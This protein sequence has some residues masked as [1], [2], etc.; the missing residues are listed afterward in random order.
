MDRVFRDAITDRFNGR[1]C[2]RVDLPVLINRLSNVVL[3]SQT[4]S[5]EINM[6]T[7][8]LLL[9]LSWLCLLSSA[10]FADDW[11]QFRGPHGNGFAD[12]ESVPTQWSPQENVLWK[13]KLP[14]P[15][16]GSAIF[17][18]DRVFVTSAENAEGTQR[19]LICFDADMG[20]DRPILFGEAR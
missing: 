18:K 7:R 9:G 4:T 5:W 14:A 11:S 12:V 1:Q 17:V 3:E 13:A 2:L 19:S 20:E 15:G 8:T 16:N 10:L 6:L